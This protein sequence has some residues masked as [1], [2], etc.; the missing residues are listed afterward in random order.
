MAIKDTLKWYEGCDCNG[1]KEDHR[2]ILDTLGHSTQALPYFI[3]SG[4]A[5]AFLGIGVLLLAAKNK[6]GIFYGC[7]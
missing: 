6:H 7:I 3:V 5:S 1:E 2:D 4:V